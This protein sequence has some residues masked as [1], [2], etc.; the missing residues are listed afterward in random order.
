MALKYPRI[1]HLALS[2]GLSL[3]ERVPSLFETLGMYTESWKRS[4]KKRLR[5][6]QGSGP[7]WRSGMSSIPCSN[8]R[9][10]RE[11]GHQSS[12]NGCLILK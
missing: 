1:E 6:R 8:R 7:L 9:N 4:F 11:T 10:D 12:M 2:K 3:I 5:R